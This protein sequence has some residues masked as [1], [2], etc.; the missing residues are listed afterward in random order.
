M[1]FMYM[2]ERTTAFVWQV[3]SGGLAFVAPLAALTKTAASAP[4]APAIRITRV[5]TAYPRSKL[6]GGYN[7]GPE[8]VNPLD[9]EPPIRRQS[10]VKR[11]GVTAFRRTRSRAGPR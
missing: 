11:R 10:G 1:P 6:P 7:D 2:I 8:P 5:P 3:A 9:P 4:I